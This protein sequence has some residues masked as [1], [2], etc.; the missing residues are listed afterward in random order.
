MD[1]KTINN[2]ILKGCDIPK[3]ITKDSKF[4]NYLLGNNIAFRYAQ[5][6]SKNKNEMD[7]KIIN[8]GQVFDNKFLITLKIVNKVCRQNKVKFLLF[9]SY[10]Y[11][12]EVVDGDIDI[13]IKEKDFYIFMGAL[14]QEGFRCIENEKLKAVC[15]KE[16]YCNIEP[17]VDAS[18]HGVKVLNNKVIWD[19]AVQV[20]IKDEKV[21]T[22]AKEVD[23]LYLLLSI[24]YRPDYLK[25]Y[26]LLVYQSAD[27]K[28]MN[29][30]I[31][32]SQIRSDLAY[33]IKNL[34]TGDITVKRFPLFPSNIS[35]VIWWFKRMLPNSQVSISDR[36]KNILFF[37]YSKYSFY[38]LNRLVFS[39]RWPV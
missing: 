20:N 8:A 6:L 28:K 22:A 1:Y 32:D 36:I 26:L 39:H 24:L 12:G 11:F 9:K 15:I 35:F 33:V 27:I 21:P 13:L 2:A 10:K 23:L 38:F 29:N 25:L 31:R 34:M 37:F 14:E 17:R 7:K 3:N 5:N 16:G 30:L 19:N 4:Y 18:V